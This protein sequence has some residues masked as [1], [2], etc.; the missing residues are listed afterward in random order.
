M[1]NLLIKLY[2][3]NNTFDKQYKPC[4][5]FK[6]NTN[7]AC[8]FYIMT[9]NEFLN[10]LYKYYF[11]FNV[12]RINLF[13]YDVYKINYSKL[14]NLF[15]KPINIKLNYSIESKYNEIINQLDNLKIIRILTI[16]KLYEQSIKTMEFA[17]QQY[18]IYENILISISNQNK[19]DNLITL[20]LSEPYQY[21]VFCLST[22]II[23]N[24]PEI[25]INVTTNNFEYIYDKMTKLLT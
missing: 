11:D 22:K 9:H 21:H 25:S 7:I 1:D 19:Y 18:D 14:V 12:I 2:Q 10:K 16:K 8:F 17:E 6:L 4:L 20:L 13:T 3:F 24:M 23:I 5:F 15:N